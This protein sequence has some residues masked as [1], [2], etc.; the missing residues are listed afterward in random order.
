[1]EFQVTLEESADPRRT[2]CSRILIQ[3]HLFVSCGD[4]RSVIGTWSNTTMFLMA[5]SYALFL[6]YGN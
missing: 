5:P 6:C 2:R 3:G 4:I 1:M